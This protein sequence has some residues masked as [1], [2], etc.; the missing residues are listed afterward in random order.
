MAISNTI[1]HLW[2]SQALKR[3]GETITLSTHIFSRYLS[4]EVHSQTR[5]YSTWE[6]L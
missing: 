2:Q 1:K 3:E 5:K 4:F 6:K